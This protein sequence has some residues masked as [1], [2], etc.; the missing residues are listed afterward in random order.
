MKNCSKYIAK[1][2]PFFLLGVYAIAYLCLC[3]LFIYWVGSIIFGYTIS[4]IKVLEALGVL[5]PSEGSVGW[6]I[7]LCYSIIMTIAFIPIN[8]KHRCFYKI[9]S[10]FVEPEEEERGNL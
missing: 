4:A 5:S 10:F 8:N 2:L 7:P 3:A 6:I 1:G 9:R